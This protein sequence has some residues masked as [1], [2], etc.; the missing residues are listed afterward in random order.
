MWKVR[1]K[2]VPVIIPALGTIKKGLYQKLQLLPG[3]PSAR[4]VLQIALMNSAHIILKSAG[5]NRFDFLL[6]S[7]LIRRP[8]YNNQ[9]ATINLM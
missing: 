3:Q 1:T 8:L 5:G 4:E 2:T 7:G 6:T 9:Q